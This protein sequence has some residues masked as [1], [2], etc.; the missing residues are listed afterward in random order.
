MLQFITNRYMMIKLEVAAQP[1]R[2]RERSLG[3]RHSASIANST[4]SDTSEG[5]LYKDFSL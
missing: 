5:L 3:L 2:F 4:P 1:P